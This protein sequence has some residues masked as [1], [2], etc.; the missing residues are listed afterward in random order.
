MGW[1]GCW[2]VDTA[3]TACPWGK[4][5]AV[6]G[7]AGGAA[8]G[9][10]SRV[11]SWTMPVPDVITSEPCRWVSSVKVSPGAGSDC[12]MGSS[13]LL[14]SDLSMTIQADVYPVMFRETSGLAAVSPKVI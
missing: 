5:S 7:T 3:T 6:Y 2:P 9:I 8:A 13:M 4:V 1:P 12:K 11:T 14:G 10:G